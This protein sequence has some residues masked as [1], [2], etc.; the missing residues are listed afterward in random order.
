MPSVSMRRWQGS[1]VTAVEP[2]ETVP[3]DFSIL[4]NFV[5]N[6][7]GLPMPRG[8]RQIWGTT[9]LG[10]GA[11]IEGLF[12]FKQGWVDSRPRDFVLC[13]AGGSVYQSKY[14]LTNPWTE[15]HSGLETG[16]VPTFAVLRDWVILSSNSESQAKPLFWN[17]A[18]STMD[19]L[20]T[21]PD[22]SICAVHANRLWLV[23]QNQPSRLHYSAPFAPSEWRLSRG[24]GY[25]EVGPGDGNS[26]SA[27]VPGYAG[28]MLVFK[29]GPS[30]GA[31]YRLQ[32]QS[33]L[34]F[35]ISPLSTS[36]G[37]TGPRAATLI[38]DRD[39]FFASR[40]GIHTVRRVQEFGD[41]ESGNIDTE[42]SDV[43]RQI[44]DK[45]KLGAVAVDDYLNDT[46]WLWYDSD[47]DGIND[48][49]I[50]WNYR[51]QNARGN[52][53]ISSV[54]FGA[55]SA[56]MARDDGSYRNLLL[57]GGSDG[58]VRIENVETGADE[59]T[60][61]VFSD[62]TW[63]ARLMPIDAGDFAPNK[64]WQK[65]WLTHENWGNADMTVRWWCDD[66]VPSS[67]TRGQN[68]N[69]GPS[70]SQGGYEIGEFRLAPEPDRALT[71]VDLRRGGRALTLEFSGSAGR[72]V[73]R[74]L[75]IDY[76]VKAPNLTTGR[77]FRY[78]YTRD[79]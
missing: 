37:C 78:D 48:K 59:T 41:L 16:I 3:G 8:G 17:G 46:W 62:F 6:R 75:R 58:Y 12:H 42:I 50:L 29:D 20:D 2:E 5:Y 51:H 32:G 45:A 38:G 55:S 7:A 23:D 74:Q 63:T 10:S 65:V 31:I 4:E 11:T 13:L 44:S 26:I 36:L 21:A 19:E 71:A 1:L 25:F 28:E 79:Q 68:P 33:E 61:G 66:Q 76:D 43:W 39:C 24:S 53:K 47:G 56:V 22:S 27:L 40:R 64:A 54:N 72:P 35:T 52:P 69:D 14:E 9:Q 30:G 67:A 57:T 70:P 34:N 15:I 18:R 73:L 60:P 77:W 49:G